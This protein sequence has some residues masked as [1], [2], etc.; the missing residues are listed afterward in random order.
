VLAV[1]PV[2]LEPETPVVPAMGVTP[3]L[4]AVAI[5]PLLVAAAAL[6]WEFAAAPPGWASAGVPTSMALQS[7]DDAKMVLMGLFMMCS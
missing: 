6:A 5:P 4:L 7:S 3:A 1:A 2:L